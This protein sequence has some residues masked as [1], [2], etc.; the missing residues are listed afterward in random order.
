MKFSGRKNGPIRDKEASILL[1]FRK[2]QSAALG[3]T[4]TVFTEMCGPSAVH[5]Q[6]LSL[7]SKHTLHMY[8]RDTPW[9]GNKSPMCL[10]PVKFCLYFYFFF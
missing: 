4:N 5:K 9:I 2:P 8:I 6:A 1:R 3:D 7:R 10:A